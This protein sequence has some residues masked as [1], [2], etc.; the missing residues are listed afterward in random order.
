MFFLIILHRPW[1]PTSK[2]TQ[3]LYRWELQ[4]VYHLEQRILDHGKEGDQVLS[5]NRLFAANGE[6]APTPVLSRPFS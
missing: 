5:T 2:W 6:V 4:Q 1:S 3:A